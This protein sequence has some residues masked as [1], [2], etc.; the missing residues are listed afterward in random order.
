MALENYMN[1]PPVKKEETQPEKEVQENFFTPEIKNEESE[2]KNPAPTLES[3]FKN[4]RSSTPEPE[5]DLSDF[6]GMDIGEILEK[7][8]TDSLGGDIPETDSESD[9]S[10]GERLEVDSEILE[11][12]VELS[13]EVF[14]EILEGIVETGARM[15]SGDKNGN[16]GFDKK[17]KERYKKVTALIAAKRKVKVSPETLF[18]LFTVYLIGSVGYKAHV[19]KK[20]LIKVSAFRNKAPKVEKKSGQISLPFEPEQPEQ[21]S[22]STIYMPESDVNRKSWEVDSEGYYTKDSQGQYIKQK[23]RSERPSEEMAAFF[24]AFKAEHK[25]HPSNKQ[26]KAYLKTL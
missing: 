2:K 20:E 19:R 21:K 22:D 6:S 15:Y 7:S 13:S 14:V 4:D 24:S 18:A 16:F 25:A 23:D 12:T 5:K 3:I 9:F 10:E 8:I 17:L 26:V 11:D 1:T